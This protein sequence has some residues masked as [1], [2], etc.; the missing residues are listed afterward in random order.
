[1]QLSLRPG[2]PCGL[3]CIQL[4]QVQGPFQSPLDEALFNSIN[5]GPPCV[6]KNMQKDQLHVK[7]QVQVWG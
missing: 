3:C 2:D 1:M 6:F 7:G 5:K 4:L